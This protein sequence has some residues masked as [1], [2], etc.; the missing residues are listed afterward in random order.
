MD[1]RTALHTAARRY[2]L[3]GMTRSEPL[4]FHLNSLT[5]EEERAVAAHSV[6]H[7]ILD[8]IEH[9]IPSAFTTVNALQGFL[10]EAGQAAT[11]PLPTS[12]QIDEQ[13]EQMH[14]D[15][16]HAFCVYVRNLSPQDLRQVPPLPYRRVL[17]DQEAEALWKRVEWC[18]NV[19]RSLWYP[20]NNEAPP[21]NVIAFDD[22]WLTTYVPP[23]ILRHILAQRRVRR[24]WQLT[25]WGTQYEMDLD[26]LFS[27][28][29]QNEAYWTSETM[30]W[31]LYQS[32][33][34][35]LTVAGDWLISAIKQAWPEWHEHL[36]MGWE[37]RVLPPLDTAQRAFRST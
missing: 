5:P 20:L 6:L 24:V 37:N 11:V 18:W 36:Y 13:W 19:P 32:H 2:C 8:E 14:S 9:V 16:R 1:E 22:A 35:S 15:A 27:S 31:L 28:S 26:L 30:D 3:E 10:I 12:E 23:T 34:Y 7:I 25:T 33:E 29:R 4:F 21:A 17:G